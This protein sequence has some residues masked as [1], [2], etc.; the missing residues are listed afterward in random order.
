MAKESFGAWTRYFDG[1]SQF[2]EGGE[3]QYGIAN[4][5]FYEYVL[6][7]LE[8]CIDTCSDLVKMQ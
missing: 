1:I 6:E 4:V 8:V 5:N 2:L 7:R 3:C